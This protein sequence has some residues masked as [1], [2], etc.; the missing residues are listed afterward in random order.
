VGILSTRY[1][2]V[3][4]SIHVGTAIGNNNIMILCKIKNNEITKVV[5][6]QDYSLY[7]QGDDIVFPTETLLRNNGYINGHF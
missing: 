4:R 5:S 6:L 1:T 3:D 7:S 2:L